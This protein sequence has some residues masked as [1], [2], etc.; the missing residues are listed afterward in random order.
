MARRRKVGDLTGSES[1]CYYCEAVIPASSMR[2]PSCGKFFSSAKKL[3]AFSV[4][5]IVVVASL[6][7]LIYVKFLGG[8]LGGGDGLGPGPEPNDSNRFVNIVTSLGTIKIE[9]YENTAPIT[10][11]HFIN[12]VQA[13]E[14][15][16]SANFY[17][18]ETNF[19]IQGG[20]RQGLATTVPWENNG[21]LN[22]AYTISMARSGSPNDPDDSASGSSEFFINLKHNTNLD[23]LTETNTMG[24]EYQYVVFGKVVSG[25]SIVDQIALFPTHDEGGI[26]VLDNPVAFESVFVSDS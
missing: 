4:V 2:C 20:L 19:V 16:T 24:V 1:E 23:P 7:G 25:T 18:A 13:G 21:L 26:R 14:F 12:L 10:A 3:I 15:D 11:T 22:T 6:S 9:M 8:H 17:R 5:L